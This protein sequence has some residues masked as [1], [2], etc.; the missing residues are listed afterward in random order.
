MALMT[1][2]YV[3]SL[4]QGQVNETTWIDILGYSNKEGGVTKRHIINGIE[5]K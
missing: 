3:H 1:G 2:L 5:T 4:R